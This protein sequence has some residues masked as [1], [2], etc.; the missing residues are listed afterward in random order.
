MKTGSGVARSGDGSARLKTRAGTGS[1]RVACRSRTRPLII[2][3]APSRT[4]DPRRPVT[5]RCGE[6]LADFAGLSLAEFSRAFARANV[7][8]EWP[9]SAG[10]KGDAFPIV[11]A[12]VRA[13]TRL[14]PRFVRGRTVVLLGRR[15]A[16]AFHISAEYFEAFGSYSATVYVVPHPSGIN[17]WYNDAANVRKMRRFMRS[18]AR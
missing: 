1:R 6:T 9:G 16:R 10:L 17:R 11:H 2:G 7:F 18:L 4:S 15:V 12:R 5:G 3:E 8:D 13:D 14:R